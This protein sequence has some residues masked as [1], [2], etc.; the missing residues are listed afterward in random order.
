M[1]RLTY[2]PDGERGEPESPSTATR[3][4]V[5]RQEDVQVTG[6]GVHTVG[7][8]QSHLAAWEH[9][10]ARRAREEVDLGSGERERENL[11]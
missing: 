3:V 1:K 9:R 10:S 6:R 7:P 5:T 8:T 11:P 4:L 2:I